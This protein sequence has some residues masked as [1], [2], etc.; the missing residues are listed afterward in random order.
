MMIDAILVREIRSEGVYR[1]CVKKQWVKDEGI[2]VRVAREVCEIKVNIGTTGRS[3]RPS[4][5][6]AK[7]RKGKCCQSDFVSQTNSTMSQMTTREIEMYR[8]AYYV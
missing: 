8:V 1:C 2:G 4:V 6:C 3:A 5:M 7:L